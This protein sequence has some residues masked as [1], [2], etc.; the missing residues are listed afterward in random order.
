MPDQQLADM[1]ESEYK[2]VYHSV[3]ALRCVFEKAVLTGRYNC[4]KVIRINIAEREAVGC[5]DPGAQKQCLKLL[6]LFRENASF[7]IKMIHVSSKLPHAKEIRIQ[8]GGLNGLQKTLADNSTEKVSSNP[9][10]SGIV[11]IYALVNATTNEYRELEKLPFQEIIKSITAY[12]SR[13]KK[14][15]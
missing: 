5:T 8:C 13:K 10:L 11:N 1:D 9:G 6:N 15:S 14:P 3:N 4:E 2:E 7:S 12:S